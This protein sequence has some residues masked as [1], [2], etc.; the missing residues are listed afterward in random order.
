MGNQGQAVVLAKA[1]GMYRTKEAKKTKTTAAT[2]RAVFWEQPAP[3][4]QTL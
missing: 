1:E 4:S 2:K 3:A